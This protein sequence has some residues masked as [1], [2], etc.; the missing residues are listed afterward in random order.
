MLSKNASLLWFFYWP[1]LW[2]CFG[3]VSAG[4][5]QHSE[6]WDLCQVPEYALRSTVKFGSTNI[7][8]SL[9]RHFSPW[10]L[11]L[12]LT[13]L[14]K[15]L[16]V[17]FYVFVVA[18][19]RVEIMI[20]ATLCGFRRASE[21]KTV[22][23]L[24]ED[25]LQDRC[26]SQLFSSACHRKLFSVTLVC[27]LLGFKARSSFMWLKSGNLVH[28]DHGKPLTPARKGGRFKY[29]LLVKISDPIALSSH[30]VWMVSLVGVGVLWAWLKLF[31]SLL[32]LFY[33]SAPAALKGRRWQWWMGFQLRS[34]RHDFQWEW[35][36]KRT[37]FIAELSQFSLSFHAVFPCVLP[38]WRTACPLLLWYSG[39]GRLLPHWG[40]PHLRVQAQEEHLFEEIWAVWK[41]AFLLQEG[42]WTVQRHHG[43]KSCR[44]YMSDTVDSR[45][46]LRSD[47]FFLSLNMFSFLSLFICGAST[48]SKCDLYIFPTKEE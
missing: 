43:I 9:Q 2:G 22:T 37:G 10:K 28:V 25:Q 24:L 21:G 17:L 11:D 19:K 20:I 44:E 23:V 45:M 29:C 30:P 4:N 14:P 40:L 34:D 6:L 47:F 42:Q 36:A 39:A 46:K 38:C 18:V 7:K 12:F 31:G 27:F 3:I 15:L 41:W 26:F 13:T 32:A 35:R 33:L 16:A 48:S 5:I 1:C 8:F